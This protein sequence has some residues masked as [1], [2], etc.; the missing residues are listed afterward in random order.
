V[1]QTGPELKRETGSKTGPKKWDTNLSG[2]STGP[3]PNLNRTSAGL[4]SRTST[5]TGNRLNRLNWQP[6]QLVGNRLNWLNWQPAQPR[7][8]GYQPNRLNWKLVMWG[9]GNQTLGNRNWM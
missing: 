6:A 8:D 9:T 5:G 3:Q 4:F 1:D 7:T 2:F